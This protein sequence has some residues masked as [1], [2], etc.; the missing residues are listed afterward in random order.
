MQYKSDTLNFSCVFVMKSA[1]EDIYYHIEDFLELIFNLN[2]IEGFYLSR[3][4]S[5][6]KNIQFP[7]IDLKNFEYRIFTAYKLEL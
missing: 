5:K 2:F 7:E 6:E 1:F 4:L 3:I